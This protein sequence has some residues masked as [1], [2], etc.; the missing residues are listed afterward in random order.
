MTLLPKERRN[1]ILYWHKAGKSQRWIARA[2]GTHR[3]TV[4]NTIRFVDDPIDDDDDEEEE[5]VF[6][7]VK[8]FQCSGCQK[9][10]KVRP[11]PACAAKR[12]KE[13]EGVK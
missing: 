6:R 3:D 8:K 7:I 11:C 13:T 2:T 9:W 10:I 4:A 1:E 12:F 5:I